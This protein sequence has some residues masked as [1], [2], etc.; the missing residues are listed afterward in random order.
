MMVLH[1]KNSSQPVNQNWVDLYIAM[2]KDFRET[3]V[4]NKSKPWNNTNAIISFISK[5]GTCPCTQK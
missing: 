2:R 4:S 3:L 1:R 5:L